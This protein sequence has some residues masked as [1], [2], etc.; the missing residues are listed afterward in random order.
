MAEQEDAQEQ[1]KA[2][3]LYLNKVND[4]LKQELKDEDADE[5]KKRTLLEPFSLSI[6][7]KHIFQYGT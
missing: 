5:K 6:N 7:N 4:K 3:F 1:F 2:A